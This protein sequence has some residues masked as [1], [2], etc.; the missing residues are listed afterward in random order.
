MIS[1]L[2]LS[3]A[4]RRFLDETIPPKLITATSVVPPP[5]SITIDPTGS[6][7]GKR[8]PIAPRH[9]LFNQVNLARTGVTSSVTHSSLLYIGYTR[10]YAHHHPRTKQFLRHSLKSLA[11]EVGQHLLSSF[12]V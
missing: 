11:D 12:E 3:P 9:R 4:I 10:G 7:T 2:S 1:S 8:G 6:F 5:M